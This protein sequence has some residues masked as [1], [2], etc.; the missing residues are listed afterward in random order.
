MI[1]NCL[2]ADLHDL[3]KINLLMHRSKA[4]WGYDDA[5]MDKFMQLFQMTAD[6]LEKNTVK[7]FCIL[8]HD[9]SDKTIGFYSFSAS[10]KG[11]E[12]DNFFIDPNYIG[13]GFGKKMWL[14]MVEDF[15]AHGVNKF[16][17]WSDPGAETFY[18]KM[19]CIKIGVKKSPMMSDRYPVIFEYEI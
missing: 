19:G 4:H 3:P 9:Q 18:K 15:K 7:L 14:M 5:F 6:Y 12:L 17:L 8:D 11:P 1:V 13:K 10:T 2:Q 16:I